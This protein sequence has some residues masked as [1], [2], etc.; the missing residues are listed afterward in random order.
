MG[1]L[2]LDVDFTEFLLFLTSA[3]VVVCLLL[4]LVSWLLLMIGVV[5]ATVFE[6]LLHAERG[7]A[8][9]HWPQPG[10]PRQ[11]LRLQAEGMQ[12]RHQLY[13]DDLCHLW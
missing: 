10:G 2:L 5:V 11:G 6:E 13:H 9:E 12:Q 1:C 7:T 4:V 3:A 8:N